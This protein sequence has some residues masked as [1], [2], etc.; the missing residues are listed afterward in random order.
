MSNLKKLTQITLFAII[1]LFISFESIQSMRANAWYFN[2]LNTLKQP[3]DLLTPQELS[4]ANEAITLATQLEPLQAHYWQLSAYIK[5]LSLTKNNVSVES[6]PKVYKQVELSLLN[7]LKH[8]TSWAETWIDLAKVTSY[9]E[10]A[11]DRVFGYIQQAKKAG[12]Y[13]IGVHLGIIEIALVNWPQLPPKYKALYVSELSLAA[14]HGYKFSR[15][16]EIAKQTNTLPT[17]CLSLQFGAQFES[18][19]NSWM[20]KKHCK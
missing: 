3:S 5:M 19:R 8:R 7:S 15:A 20:F 10:G 4:L 6:A 9:Q 1:T 2:A 16:F 11:S 13:K 18:A 12:P 14:K 17:L